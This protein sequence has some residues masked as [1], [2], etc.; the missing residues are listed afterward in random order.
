MAPQQYRRPIQRSEHRTPREYVTP[1]AC[2]FSS[3]CDRLPS[4]SCVFPSRCGLATRAPEAHLHKAALAP[5]RLG[6]LSTATTTRRIMCRELLLGHSEAMHFVL[7]QIYPSNLIVH[8]NILQE[9]DQLQATANAVR[10]AQSSRL[11]RCVEETKKQLTH[12]I[13]GAPGNSPLTCQ[14]NGNA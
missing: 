6:I 10:P 7:R 3:R 8:R 4:Q 11:I 9:V 1:A 13:G 12:R 2:R 14:S 5:D